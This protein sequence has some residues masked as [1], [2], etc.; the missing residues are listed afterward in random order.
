MIGF[1]WDPATPWDGTP[2]SFVVEGRSSADIVAGLLP[3][4]VT[5][6]EGDFYAARLIDALGLREQDGVVRVS[7]VHYNT[8]DE[9]D[10]LIRGLDELL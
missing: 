7:M 2:I 6:R 3:H 8:L 5:V 10:R 4:K 9:V 1:D